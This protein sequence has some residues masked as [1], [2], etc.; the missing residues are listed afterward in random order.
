MKR[1]YGL[2][3]VVAL[4]ALTVVPAFA[5]EGDPTIA[6][7]VVSST[8]AE[9]P[10]FTTLL[11]AVQAADPAV[12][13][14]LS[15]PDANVT[16]F[17][18]TDAAFSAALEALGVTAED[19]LADTAMLNDILMYHVVPGAF[20]SGS[21]VELDGALLGTRLHNAAL[22]ISAADGSVMVNDAT[23]ITADVAA[24]NGVVHIIDSVLLPPTDDS[25]MEESMATE[26]AMTEGDTMAGSI[27]DVV[28]A[29]AG[30]E[31]PEFTTLLAAVQAADPAVLAELTGAGPYT[32]FAPTDAA[33]TAALEA[34]GLTADELLADTETLTSIL[35]YHV[36]PGYFDAETAIAVASSMDGGEPVATALNGTTVQLTFDGTTLFVNGTAVTMA[37][38]PA[39]N[40]IIH[41]VDGVLLPPA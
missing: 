24:S 22:T 23:V 27:A 2:L 36:V 10:E 8:Q 40:G 35:A 15:N 11:A 21:I 14:L 37:D 4:L 12:L 29:S 20:A 39:D 18:P 5:Q 25:M 41:V 38:I 1:L 6:E 34:L 26:E 16:V 32:V 33:F 30:G 28:I 9:S 3:A 19:L 31:T 7:I 17:A 13:E